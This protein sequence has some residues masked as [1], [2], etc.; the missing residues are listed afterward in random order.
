MATAPSNDDLMHLL[1]F[2]SD[3]LA[4]NR[5]GQLS[6]PQRLHLLTE[7]NFLWPFFLVALPVGLVT[8]GLAGNVTPI[9]AIV[10]V[11]LTIAAWRFSRTSLQIIRTVLEGKILET[12]GTI[13]IRLYDYAPQTFEGMIGQ[14]FANGIINDVSFVVPIEMATA[15]QG[16]LLRISYTE[17][18]RQAVAGE[19]LAK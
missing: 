6:I 13:T 5:T 8:I 16:K 14:K 7:I 19:V 17:G 10:A 4:L 2:D 3:D 18:Y 12:S 11:A 9:Q 15:Y 1:N